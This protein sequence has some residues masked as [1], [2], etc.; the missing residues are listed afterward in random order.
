ML[1]N[2]FNRFLFLVQMNNALGSDL[3]TCTVGVRV[4]FDEDGVLVEHLGVL[5]SVL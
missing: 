1:L 4:I 2:Y 3:L 5:I